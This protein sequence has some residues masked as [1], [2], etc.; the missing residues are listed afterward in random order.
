MASRWARE[1]RAD[2]NKRTGRDKRIVS[3]F[4]IYLSKGKSYHQKLIKS[5]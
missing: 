5:S 3:F 2:D 1:G 4:E